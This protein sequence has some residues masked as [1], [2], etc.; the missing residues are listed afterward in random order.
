MNWCPV[1]L[2]LEHALHFRICLS[3]FVFFLNT[4][5][6]EEEEVCLSVSLSE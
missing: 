5:I 6:T 2:H 4:S 1:R 3:I